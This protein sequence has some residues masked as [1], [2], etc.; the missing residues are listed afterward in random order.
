[1]GL[2]FWNGRDSSTSGFAFR[3]GPETDFDRPLVDLIFFIDASDY[4]SALHLWIGTAHDIFIPTLPL[5]S[6]VVLVRTGGALT[7]GRSGRSSHSP[8]PS[9]SSS[10]ST[11]SSTSATSSTSTSSW[12]SDQGRWRRKRASDGL[13]ISL[14]EVWMGE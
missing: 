2:A 9:S 3:E 4:T 12:R 5:C 13:Y 8:P 10:S 14:A 1:M 7:T 11:S 6:N